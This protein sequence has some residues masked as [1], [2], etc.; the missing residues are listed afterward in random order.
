VE[1]GIFR[2][3]HNPSSPEVDIITVPHGT[4]II[5]QKELSAPFDIYTL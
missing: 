1:R 5:R 2:T 3:A 4:V